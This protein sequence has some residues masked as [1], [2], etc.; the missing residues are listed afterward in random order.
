MNMA[1]TQKT[2]QELLTDSK[3]NKSTAFTEEER[4]QYGLVGLLPPAVET[5]DAQAKRCLE[6]LAV[7][8]TDL[9]RYIY[10]VQLFDDNQTLFFKV[11]STDPARF[12]PIV[13]DPTVAEACLKFGHLYRKPNG[14]YLTLE[15]KGRVK[16]ILAEWPVKDVRFI[17]VSTG[18]RILGLGD[19]GANGMGIPIG[20][21]QLYTACAAVPPDVLLPLLL[22]CGTN[23]EQYLSDPL[24]LGLKRK[25]PSTDELD[26]FVQEFVDAVQDVFPRCCI[27]FED[28]KGTD[29]LR[30]LKRYVGQVC[31]YND[32]VQGTGSVTVAGLYNALKISGGDLKDQRVLFLG[33]GSAGIGIADMIVSAMTLEGLSQS[34]AESRISLFDVNGLLEPSQTNLTP[35]QQKYAHPHAPSKSLVDTI[36]S[37]KPTI[38]IGVSTAGGAFTEEVVQAM[39]Q[40]N[41]RPIIFALSNPTDKAECTAEQA[42]QWS[43]QKAIYAGGVQFPP[44]QADGQE[45]LPGQ[46]NNFY[47]FPAI[48]LAVYAT[49]AKRVPDE[50]FIEAARALADQVGEE[51]LKKGMLF[52]KQDD[53]LWVEVQTATKVAEKIFDLNLAGI[54]KPT[55]VSAL[56]QDSLYKFSY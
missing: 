35:D 39:T 13:Y 54:N 43:G 9:E 16:D 41:K 46:A 37:L 33:A 3:Q 23:N 56:I 52:P 20:K 48:G 50:L 2:G 34:D 31:C 8:A 53:I 30:L 18:E 15:H 45:F 27:H 4:Q 55:D 21:L 42:Y 10:L 51:D 6:Q 22:D 5:L 32:D 11:L 17:C 44:V 12:L 24:Y 47:V 36:K 29:A 49:Q 26:A 1:D 14:I 28:W 7:K 19:I 38:L 25:R 40:L